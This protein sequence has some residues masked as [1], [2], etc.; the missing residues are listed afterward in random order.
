MEAKITEV[1]Q[2][3]NVVNVVGTS[4]DFGQYWIEHNFKSVLVVFS[5]DGK[6]KITVFNQNEIEISCNKKTKI[7]H[8]RFGVSNSAAKSS[9]SSSSQT[10]EVSQ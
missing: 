8:N 7:K 4:E 10:K 6:I 2:K 3:N 1:K 5:G 9:G